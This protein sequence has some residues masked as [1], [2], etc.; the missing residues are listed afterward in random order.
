MHAFHLAPSRNAIR[1]G[2][3]GQDLIPSVDD[4]GEAMIVYDDSPVCADC[5][6]E[7]CPDLLH[8]MRAVPAQ[9]MQ[10]QIISSG[11]DAA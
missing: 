8:A 1:C 2:V 10:A 5:A 4:S 3:C 6:E 7:L 9:V 11:A